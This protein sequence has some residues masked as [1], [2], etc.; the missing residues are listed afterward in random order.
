MQRALET[1]RILPY[2]MLAISTIV[3]AFGV[4]M[5]VLAPNDYPSIGI[6]IWWAVQTVT[7]VGYGDVVPSNGWGRLVASVL[8]VIGFA[9]LS[10]LTGIVASL[11]VHRRT[12]SATESGFSR[13]EQ[14]LDEVEKLLRSKP[15]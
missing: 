1:G 5:R 9:T 11:L 3:V 13:L 8:M 12:S 7:T 6:G 10:L 14:R 2:M 4:L 15:S